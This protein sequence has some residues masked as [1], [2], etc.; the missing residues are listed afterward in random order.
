MVKFPKYVAERTS[1]GLDHYYSELPKANKKKQSGTPAGSS[2]GGVIELSDDSD[3]DEKVWKKKKC[4]GGRGK[5]G[6]DNGK[7][8][9]RLNGKGEAAVLPSSSSEDVYVIKDDEFPYVVGGNSSDESEEVEVKKWSTPAAG[10][11]RKNMDKGKDVAVNVSNYESGGDDSDEEDNDD[12]N[13][14]EYRACSDDRDDDEEDV[15]RYVVDSDEGT[16]WSRIG[17]KNVQGRKK[18]FREAYKERKAFENNDQNRRKGFLGKDTKREMVG[19]S[20]DTVDD[21]DEDNDL[22]NRR[23]KAVTKND[24][25]GKK[26]VLGKFAERKRVGTPSDIDDDADEDNDVGN[27]RGKAVKKNYLGKKG[28]LGKFAERKRV[29]TPS[30]TDDDADQYNDVGRRGKTVQK[31]DHSRKKGVLGK[32]AKRKR[33]S[34]PSDTDD[35]TD[36]DNDLGSRRGKTA[37]KNDQ[38][39]KK[40]V[41]GKFGNRVRVSTPSDTGDDA[42]EDNDLGSRRGKVVRKNDQSEKKWVLGKYAKRKSVVTPC[43]TDDDA[44]NNNGLGS[45]RGKVVQKNYQSGKKGVLGKFAKRKRFGT[46]NDTNDDA[47]AGFRRRCFRRGKNLVVEIEYT[48]FSYAGDNVDIE[49][50]SSGD[51]VDIGEDRD[52]YVVDMNGIDGVN[53]FVSTSDLSNAVDIGDGGGSDDVVAIGDGNGVNKSVSTSDLSDAGEDMDIIKDCGAEDAAGDK[54]DSDKVGGCDNADIGEGIHSDHVDVDN[55]GDID[56]DKGNDHGEMGVTKEV[57]LGM[58]RKRRNLGT[59]SDKVTLKRSSSKSCFWNDGEQGE[60]HEKGLE[61]KKRCLEKVKSIVSDWKERDEGSNA[62]LEKSFSER[63]K[64]VLNDA[65]DKDV[66]GIDDYVEPDDEEDYEDSDKDTNKGEDGADEVGEK[67]EVQSVGVPPVKSLFG[68]FLNTIRE[69]DGNH[70]NEESVLPNGGNKQINYK[71]NFGVETPKPV[72]KTEEEKYLE[73]LW[74]EYDFAV[75]VASGDVGSS[76]TPAV[77][78]EDANESSV[79]LDPSTTCCYGKQGK[80]DFVIDDE[81]GI[82]CRFCSFVHLEMK[83]VLPPLVSSDPGKGTVWNIFPRIRESMY[84]HQQ[85]GFEFLW[86]NI[87]GGLNIENL[88]NSPPPDHIGGCVISHAPGTGKTFLTIAFLRSYMEIFKES[89]AVIMAPASMLLTWEEEFKKWKIDIPFHNLNSWDFTGRE[90]RMVHKLIQGKNRNNKWT[91][92]V[93]LLSW[94]KEKSV[95]GISYNLFEKH[96]GDRFVKGRNKEKVEMRRIL[97]EKPGL[98]VFDEG[99]TPRNKH[100]LIWKALG[101]VKTDKRI[102]LYGTPFQNNFDE[103]YNTLCL[104]RPKFAEKFFPI[105]QAKSDLR[106]QDARRLWASLTN[107]IGKDDDQSLLDPLISLID[108]F[109]NAHRGSLTLNTPGDLAISLGTSDTFLPPMYKWIFQVFGIANVRNRCAERSWDTFNNILEQ[110]PPLNGGKLGFYY[111]EHE[112]LPPLPVGYH[113]YV[114]ENF[115]GSTLDVVEEREVAE[116]DA[117]SEV[118]GIIEGPFLSMRAHAERFG[119]P[120]PPNRIIATGGASANSSIL[121]SVASIFGCDVYTVQRSDSASLGAALR[122]AHGWLCNRKGSFI[123][124]SGIYENKLENSSVSCKL[125]MPAGDAQLLSKYTLLMKKRMEIED[126]LVQ[127][128]GRWQ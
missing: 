49:E 7:K 53:K 88:R 124:F 6:F 52:E 33:V 26:G 84:H 45:R 44:D 14:E 8:F 78:T 17:R 114:L 9:E 11:Q 107:S 76:E 106:S 120:A 62:E 80:H 36:N 43:D 61:L 46:P 39:G 59:S 23:G 60:R 99:H 65:N 123:P 4:G 67:E 82:K 115:T 126:C 12:S 97:L 35:D 58:S 55:G 79:E 54:L 51:N 47:D 2:R 98:L 94:S 24:Q 13:D 20:S 73:M 112:I 86:K 117:P 127:K 128:L 104:V 56:I 75:V 105:R 103:L 71:F 10:L 83:Y 48:D 77:D 125:S 89:R 109:V 111:K 90:G 34:T 92:L 16:I 69:N 81:I 31:N 100:S 110:T 70:H 18:G 40:G 19:S 108:P 85:E 30:D 50:G 96:A 38:S 91:R 93:K 21:A 15:E 27:G 42:D 66:D 113:R 121:K 25:S 1:R 63:G 57:H 122:A 116:F 28:V 37:Q 74:S 101:N 68:F 118:R 119:M 87:A 95:L 29:G 64:N 72:E 5:R 22:G 102:I 41:L 3:D 32:F